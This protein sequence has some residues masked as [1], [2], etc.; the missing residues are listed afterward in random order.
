[1]GNNTSALQL[2]AKEQLRALEA[3]G[4]ELRVKQAEQ[5]KALMDSNVEKVVKERV[6]RTASNSKLANFQARSC[7]LSGRDVNGWPLVPGEKV[8]VVKRDAEGW[9]RL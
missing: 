9:P 3:K 4:R 1:M 5:T 6:E 7:N 2:K 8:I